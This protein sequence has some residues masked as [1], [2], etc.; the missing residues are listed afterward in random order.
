MAR[1]RDPDAFDAE[2]ARIRAAA[3]ACFV[4]HGLHA[5]GIAEICR[6]AGI[7]AGRFYHYFPSKQDLI[8][9][10]AAE[11]RAATQAWLDILAGLRGLPALL[12]HLTEVAAAMADPA[13]GRLALE[14]VAEAGR[15]STFAAPFRDT[16]ALVHRHLTAILE[17]ARTRG[18]IRLDRPPA[19][20]ARQVRMLLDGVVGRSVLDPDDTPDRVAADIRDALSRLLTPLAGPAPLP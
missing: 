2:R 20:L 9:A 16:A 1:T 8:A 15:D 5:A 7:S 19:D 14:L 11:D 6:E 3:E 18:E 13:Y 4:R 10:V 17:A 12:D